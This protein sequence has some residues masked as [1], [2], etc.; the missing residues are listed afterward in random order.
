MR[1]C[2]LPV[3]FGGSCVAHLPETGILSSGPLCLLL[4]RNKINRDAE[5][6]LVPS[7]Y[8]SSL[9][10]SHPR[11]CD[12]SFLAEFPLAEVPLE[13][14]PFAVLLPFILVSGVCIRSTSSLAS[15]AYAAVCLGMSLKLFIYKYSIQLEA[16]D[17]LLILIY[18]WNSTTG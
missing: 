17:H 14:L 7:G 3:L 4:L 6:N 10:E 9:L 16:H 2:D 1:R 13:D 18:L 15:N 11:D 8:S 5:T 12:S